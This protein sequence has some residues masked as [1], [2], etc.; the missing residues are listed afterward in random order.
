[1]TENLARSEHGA[2]HHVTPSI[3][4]E[5]AALPS[6]HHVNTESAALPYRPCVHA[7]LPSNYAVS[8][9]HRVRRTV[10]PWTGYEPPYT[11]SAALPYRP[12]TIHQ[13]RRTAATS[14]RRSSSSCRWWGWSPTTRAQSGGQRHRPHTIQGTKFAALPYRPCL[15]KVPEKADLPSNCAVSSRQ[16]VRSA[17]IVVALGSQGRQ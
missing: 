13:L 1:V 9:R 7:D 10:M 5:S 12:H 11:E 2:T 16:R 15:H 14:A 8:S 4:T 3:A 17:G 6:T